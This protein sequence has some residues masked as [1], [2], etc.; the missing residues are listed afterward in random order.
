M[1]DADY[2]LAVK[3]SARRVSARVGQWVNRRGPVRR[4]DSKPLAR[5]WA[6]ACSTG[7]AT[8][9]VQ[10][11]PPWADDDADGYLVGRRFRTA[12]DE[13]PGRQAT[14]DEDDR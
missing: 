3:P 1:S 2:R 9:W 12:P 8:V 5:E 4:F 11:A 6:R 7:S 10:D 13:R 14:I